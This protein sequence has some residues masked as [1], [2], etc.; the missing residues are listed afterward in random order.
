MWGQT[1]IID[2]SNSWNMETAVSAGS[3]SPGGCKN[4]YKDELVLEVDASNGTTK[5]YCFVDITN[6]SNNFHLYQLEWTPTY[7]SYKIDN[8][9]KA[10]FTTYV[11]Q[12]PIPINL[13]MCIGKCGVT[14]TYDLNP[15][16]LPFDFQIDYVRVYQ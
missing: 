12:Q 15:V 4:R 9:E 8:I 5:E 2:P 14:W 11:A 13:A 6:L 1:D 3:Y 16:D 7:M 10:R